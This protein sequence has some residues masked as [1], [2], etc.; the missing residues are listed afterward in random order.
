MFLYQYARSMPRRNMT[1]VR[2]LFLADSHLGFDLPTRPRV[3]RRRRGADFFDNFDRALTV[4][5]SGEVDLVV[6]GGDLLYR[7]RVPPSLVQSA[8][9]PLKQVADMSIPVYLVPGNHERSEIPYQMLA[10]HPNIHIFDRPRTFATEVNGTSVVLAGFPYCRNGVRGAFADL[11][12]ATGW[13]SV[14]AQINLLCVHH[15]F[16]GATV[17]PGNYTFR[18]GSDVVRVAD[19]PEEFA[20]VLSGHIHRHQILNTDLRGRALATPVLY[21][22]SIE[23][24]SFAEKDELK[25]YLVLGVAPD[26]SRGGVLRTCEFRCLPTRPM[27]LCD[28]HASPAGGAGLQRAMEDAIAQAPFDAI[29]RLQ[30]HGPLDDGARSV[31]SAAKLRSLIP[32]TMNVEVRIVEDDRSSRRR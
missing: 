15:C 6:H 5:R 32:P 30:I 10:L 11:L 12:D 2:I 18:N 20:A 3:M 27:L 29:L 9:L 26:R 23:R 1:V 21:P 14:A 17:G 16:E 22:G 13:R 31:L 24:T 8:F 7:R 25:G 28:L 19:V 4:A